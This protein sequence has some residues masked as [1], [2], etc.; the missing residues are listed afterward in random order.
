[1][2]RDSLIILCILEQILPKAFFDEILENLLKETRKRNL[3]IIDKRVLIE[4]T[5]NILQRVPRKKSYSTSKS[6]I[7]ALDSILSA[8]PRTP[9]KTELTTQKIPTRMPLIKTSKVEK[10]EHT[11]KS[12]SE[13]GATHPDLI[14]K[15]LEK[16]Q[17][18]AISPTTISKAKKTERFPELASKISNDQDTTINIESTTIDSSNTPITTP[19]PHDSTKA[20]INKQIIPAKQ[21]PKP[22][23]TTKPPSTM[24][25]P[26][27]KILKFVDWYEVKDDPDLFRS[28]FLSRFEKLRKI[29]ASHGI[30]PIITTADIQPGPY[31]EKY[32]VIMVQ[33]KKTTRDDR[34]GIIT[35]DDEF[36]DLTAFISFEKY[37]DLREKFFRIMNDSVIALRI[38]RAVSKNKIYVSDIIFPDISRPKH[39]N[40]SSRSLRILIASDFHVGSKMFMSR[41]MDNFIRFLRGEFEDPLASIADSVEYIIVTGDLVDGVG[42]YPQQ[43]SE[44]SIVDQ[45]KQYEVLAQ[46]LSKIP[47]DKLIIAIPGNH[48][49]STRLIP[50][51]PIDEEVGKPIYNLSNVKILSNPS[52]ID[53]SGVKILL[54][55]GQGFEQIA[56]LLGLQLDHA[57]KVVGELLRYRHLHPEWGKI[58]Q[59]PLPEDPLIIDP[60][61]DIVCAGHVHINSVGRYRG[62]G[63]IVS[64]AF[65]GLTSWQRDIG[66]NP[67]VGYFNIVDLHT[68]EVLT[69]V[70]DEKNVYIKEART[71]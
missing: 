12:K 20:N 65:E 68:Y 27:P 15:D 67:T 51:P 64:G 53:I 56:G 8:K 25:P 63:I 19:T 46:Y 32:V 35:G 69:L 9:K 66:I 37:P 39:R 24:L 44:L 29:I 47:D 26:E 59:A 13:R 60:E 2:S 23:A 50:Q 22:L 70:A 4:I 6:R 21:A 54:Y 36:G 55:H 42:V 45:R 18:E 16:Q 71:I 38:D 30:G 43:A 49:V 3:L 34:L 1:M 11:T 7:G 10:K 48:D 40:K 61:P 33:S 5:R 58:A 57:D 14:A 41:R 62:V 17:P 28:Y 31:H 52:T